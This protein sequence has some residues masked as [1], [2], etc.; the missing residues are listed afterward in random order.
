MRRN[1]PWPPAVDSWNCFD[2]E[3][4]LEK[5]QQNYIIYARRL[6]KF[7]R[8]CVDCYEKRRRHLDRIA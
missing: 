7:I 6:N 4:K 8:L 5:M 3:T 2:C 1:L